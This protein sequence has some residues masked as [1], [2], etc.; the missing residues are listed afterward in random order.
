MG[1]FRIFFPLGPERDEVIPIRHPNLGKALGVHYV[2]FLDDAV[3]MEQKSG[4]SVNL[5]G[6]GESPLG[7]GAWRG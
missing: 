2:A 3:L 6:A 7:A 5:A 4:Q 1:S